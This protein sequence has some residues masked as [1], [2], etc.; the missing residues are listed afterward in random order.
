M[1][2]C[3]ECGVK[4]KKALKKCPLCNTPVMKKIDREEELEVAYSK[5]IEELKHINYNYV[6]KLINLILLTIG[7]VVLISNIAIT[8]K[9]TWSIYV[10]LSL[11][12]FN[13]FLQYFLRRNIYLTHMINFIGMEILLFVIAYLNSGLNWYLYLVCPFIA[14][15]WLYI[16]LFTFLI[17]RKKGNFLRKIAISLL[18]SSYTL[19]AV[20]IAIDLYKYNKIN[21]TWSIYAALP[22]TIISA[23]IF[24][25]SYHKRLFE[26]IKQRL[27]I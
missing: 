4:L 19:M 25:I 1:T 23:I 11:A 15:L 10:L 22:I 17:N 20:E 9:V 5:A 6:G 2:Y 16:F 26:E 3:V 8:G 14:I 24:G 7:L 18:F 21:M 27:F 13:C 12:Y